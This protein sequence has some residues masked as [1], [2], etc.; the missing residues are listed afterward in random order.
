M[1][2]IDADNFK[3]FISRLPKCKN[4][5]SNVYDESSIL[6][7]I[8]NQPTAFDLESAVKQIEQRI[9]N[10]KNLNSDEQIVDV[11]I[12]EIE[13]DLEIIK[14]AVNSTNGKNGKIKKRFEMLQILFS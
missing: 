11:A 3:E 4:G 6:R 2:L 10:Y 13:R 7:F 5:H 1:R 12:K 8:E 14:S 9:Q